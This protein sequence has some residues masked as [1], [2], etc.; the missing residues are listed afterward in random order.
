MK[1]RFLKFIIFGIFKPSSP[2][3]TVVGI[4]SRY[5]VAIEEEAPL[6]DEWGAAIE[7]ASLFSL[8]IASVWVASSIE[9]GVVLNSETSLIEAEFGKDAQDYCVTPVHELGKI[10]Q[11][12]LVGATSSVGTCSSVSTEGSLMPLKQVHNKSQSWSV[13]S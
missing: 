5:K 9:M 10:R 12:S 6:F 1:F 2:L 13:A 7:E 8:E 3:E 4:T 11:V